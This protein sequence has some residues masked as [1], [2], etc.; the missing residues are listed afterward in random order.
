MNAFQILALSFLAA[1]VAW[2]ARQVVRGEIGPGRWFRVFIWCLAAVAVARPGL[3]QTAATDLGIERGADLVLYVF[4]FAFLG[5]SFFLYAQNVK[6]QREITQLV[7]YI[8]IHQA[9]LVGHE[10]GSPKAPT[11]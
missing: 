10:S 7:R 5:T 4:V 9:E 11:A 3:V 1:A 8:A 2:E 6:S